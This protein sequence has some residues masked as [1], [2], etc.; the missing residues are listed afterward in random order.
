MNN[1]VVISVFICSLAVT[2]SA[3]FIPFLNAD[4]PVKIRPKFPVR[5]SI[6]ALLIFAGSGFGVATLR[7]NQ[8]Q[9]FD[10]LW[11]TSAMIGGLCLKWLLES[12]ALK[13][14][15]M[16]EGVL[17]RALLAAPFA[18]ASLPDLF[19]PQADGS[20]LLLWGLN[21]FFW[22]AFFSDLAR[23]L[24]KEQVVIRRREPPTLAYDFRKPDIS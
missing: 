11:L 24:A 23:L 22:H 19:R 15:S 1:P 21:G 8:T 12:L 17:F 5:T 18:A 10:I 16:Q 4:L 9:I 13:K 14:P 7:A 3:G 6:L 20:Q 2:L